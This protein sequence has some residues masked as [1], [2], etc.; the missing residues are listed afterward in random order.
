M[1][2]VDDDTAAADGDAW[3]APLT[4]PTRIFFPPVC[5]RIVLQSRVPF[6]EFDP[7]SSADRRR[8]AA[9]VSVYQ[10]RFCLFR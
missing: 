7:L 8:A 2:G 9:A 5:W 6:V 3:V 1:F 10:T 4:M